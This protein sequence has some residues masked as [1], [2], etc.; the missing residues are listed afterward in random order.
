MSVCACVCVHVCVWAWVC[1]CVGVGVRVSPSPLSYP[2]HP[3][4]DQFRGRWYS[5][6]VCHTSRE[7]GHHALRPTGGD[8]PCHTSNKVCCDV[9]VHV[10]VYVGTPS[11]CIMYV[12]TCIHVLY[13]IIKPT[14]TCSSYT[15]TCTT[16][17][18]Y[19]YNTLFSLKYACACLY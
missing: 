17:H 6:F 4:T 1:T 9:H 3:Q 12:Y 19:S 18:N 11:H 15:C 13:T 2:S 16:L 10:H 5:W 14:C 8:G 7:R